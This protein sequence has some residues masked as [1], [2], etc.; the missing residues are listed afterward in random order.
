MNEPATTPAPPTASP[1]LLKG[2]RDI[3]AARS[4]GTVPSD[5]GS[6]GKSDGNDN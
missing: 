6:T 4:L 1:G 2:V 5:G 3:V